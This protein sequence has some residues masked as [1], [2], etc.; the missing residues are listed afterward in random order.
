MNLK[1]KNPYIHW[2]QQT[3]FRSK[4]TDKLKMR[5]WRKAFHKNGNKKRVK[6]MLI[7]DKIDFIF[8]IVDLFLVFGC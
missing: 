1:K 6:V 3:H 2:L 7:P 5:G 8:L 4:D